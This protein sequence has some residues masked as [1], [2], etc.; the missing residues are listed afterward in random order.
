MLGGDGVYYTIKLT[1]LTSLA[2]S[3]NTTV[4]HQTPQ[5]SMVSPPAAL[6]TDLTLLPPHMTS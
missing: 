5:H 1:A 6:Q 2:K 4:A 3:R